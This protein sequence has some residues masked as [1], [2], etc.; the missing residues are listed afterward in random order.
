MCHNTDGVAISKLYCV[1]LFPSTEN[2][3]LNGIKQQSRLKAEGP[4]RTFQLT[5]QAAITGC[6]LPPKDLIP[7]ATDSCLQDQKSGYEMK[8]WE[9]FMVRDEATAS[10]RD[11]PPSSFTWQCLYGAR[12]PSCKLKACCI[13]ALLE[14]LYN[15]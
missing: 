6:S 2:V 4:L 1:G 14:L 15:Q 3:D 12:C 5:L 10:Q 8:E 9:L 7:R 13:P 11:C